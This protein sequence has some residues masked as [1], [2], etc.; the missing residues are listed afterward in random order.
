MCRT[1]KTI[2]LCTCD[3]D[4][5]DPAASWQLE[6]RH[7]QPMSVVGDFIEPEAPP[8]DRQIM[9]AKIL[10]DLNTTACFDFDY[11]PEDG[12]QLHIQFGEDEYRLSFK[13]YLGDYG[14]WIDDTNS[15]GD[16]SDYQTVGQGNIQLG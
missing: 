11:Q 16:A 14:E 1:G 15:F 8:I 7:G 6:R 3:P 12:D 13:P 4:E 10:S 2:K 5:V 9:L